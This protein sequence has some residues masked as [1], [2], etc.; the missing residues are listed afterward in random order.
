MQTTVKIPKHIFTEY[1]YLSLIDW[2][3][4]E[5]LQN[6]LQVYP[7]TLKRRKRVVGERMSAGSAGLSAGHAFSA[8]DL[9]KVSVLMTL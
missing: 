9:A 3:K 7:Y 4:S 2:Q 1:Q 6:D 5:K 8:A